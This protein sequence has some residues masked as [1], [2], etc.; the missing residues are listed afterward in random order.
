MVISVF[1][2]VYFDKTLPQLVGR[3]HDATKSYVVI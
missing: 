3:L 2:K 1:L